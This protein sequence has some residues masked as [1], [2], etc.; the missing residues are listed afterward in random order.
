M[1]P[2]ILIAIALTGCTSFRRDVSEV[3]PYASYTEQD[4]KSVIEVGGRVLFREPGLAK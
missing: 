1:K 4:G 2:L 3:D